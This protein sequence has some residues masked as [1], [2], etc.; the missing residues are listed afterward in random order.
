[1]SF[2]RLSKLDPVPADVQGAVVL[3]VDDDP[4]WQ[5]ILE[6]DLRLLGYSP[7]M[8]ADSA[9]ALDR[10]AEIDPDVAVID[11][12]LPGS[13]GWHLVS[14]MRARGASVPTIFYSAYLMSR[15]DNHHPDVVACISKAAGKA[16]L[17]GLLPGAIR[18]KKLREA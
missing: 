12:M 5:L 16:D 3:V 13:D 7:L 10:S 15:A 8:A 6:T 1:M 18:K 17:Y 2:T 9:E 14:E 4:A 11:L